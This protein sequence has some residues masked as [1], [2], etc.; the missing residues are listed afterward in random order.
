MD[1]VFF[2][3]RHETVQKEC[4][5][6]A[7]DIKVSGNYEILGFYMNPVENHIAYGNVLIDLHERGVEEPFLFIADGLPGIEEE[8][9]Q[10]YPR[11]DFQLCTI[12]ASRNFESHV[13]VQDRN[14]ID[15][16]IKGI[17]LSPSREDAIDQFNAFKNKW[18]SKYPKRV[19]N[20]ENN[21]SYC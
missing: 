15:S 1:A 12:H 16:D 17:F 20:M 4:V 10:L 19:Y 8:I 2:S 3:L 13:R 14:E 5:I 6:F 21:L 9:K 18:S 11:A 7:M